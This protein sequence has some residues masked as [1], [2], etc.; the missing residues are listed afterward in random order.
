MQCVRVSTSSNLYCISTHFTTRYV[1]AQEMMRENMREMVGNDI[2]M[3]MCKCREI[4]I[5]QS[6]T[7]R[8]NSNK[9]GFHDRA[10][11]LAYDMP[12]MVLP[13]IDDLT[14]DV[15]CSRFLSSSFA[16]SA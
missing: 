15:N 16:A 9:Q 12:L 5:Q 1:W 4:E 3:V 6:E 7:G 13:R 8:K 2:T 11:T 14:L 10:I